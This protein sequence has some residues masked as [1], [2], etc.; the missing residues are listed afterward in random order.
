MVTRSQMGAGRLTFG[1]RF[2]RASAIDPLVPLAI[3]KGRPARETSAATLPPLGAARFALD[4]RRAGRTNAR[5][6]RRRPPA[7]A[8]VR[9]RDRSGATSRN[10]LG[11]VKD[12]PGA[13]PPEVSRWPSRQSV[14]IRG[15]RV[16]T[17]ADDDV[18][19]VLVVGETVAAI[20]RS[21][22]VPDGSRVVDAAGQ[23]VIPGGIDP[24]VH[25]QLPFGGTVSSDDFESG[26]RAAAV[27]GTTSIIDFAIQYKGKSFTQTLDDWHAKA[28]GRCAIDYGFHLAVTSYESHHA[29]E[30][31]AVI[32]GGVPTFKLFLAYPD[33]VPGR[34]PDDV[35][36]H[37]GRRRGPGG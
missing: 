3:W 13:T 12:Q 19:D 29:E 24:H 2:W 33:V 36:R 20:G 1:V 23:L 30:F 32:A 4:A 31:Q 28:A 15:G 34:R 37:A 35:P 10:C 25:M 22:P 21:L 9:W 6:I 17:A 8:A 11:C 7:F 26:T 27:G 18:A 14:L 16:V 5:S